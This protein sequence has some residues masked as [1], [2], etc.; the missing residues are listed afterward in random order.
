MIEIR[1]LSHDYDGRTV[2]HDIDIDVAKGEILVIMGSSGGGKT[3]LL[4]CLSGLL[5]PTRGSVKVA[6]IDMRSQP[7][8]ARAHIGFVFQYAALFDSL[9]VTDNILFGIRRRKRLSGKAGNAL[10]KELLEEVGLPGIENLLPSELSGG[11]RKRVGLARALALK[12]EVL[13]FDE[14][15]SGL[16]PVTAYSID[17]LIVETRQKTGAACVV[18]SHDLHS[19]VRVAD[20]IVFLH[21]GHIVFEG[22][23]KEFQES[24]DTSIRELVDKAQ[25]EALNL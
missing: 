17:Q 6:E 7:E 25:A 15:T 1:G 4:K 20:R 11:M 19:V 9:N 18:V 8:Q 16:D 13:L 14:P 3:T 5:V 22:S 21:E 24:R 2:L 23:P 12:P 10:V